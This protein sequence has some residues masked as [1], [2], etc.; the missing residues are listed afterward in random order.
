V[1]N[2]SALLSALKLTFA[3]A[4]VQYTNDDWPGNAGQGCDRF[5]LGESLNLA[6]QGRFD[7]F[8]AT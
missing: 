1:T 2:I 4:W 3:A 6:R 5:G 8:E 7:G